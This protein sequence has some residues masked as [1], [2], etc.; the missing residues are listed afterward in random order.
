MGFQ[1]R[2]L[3]YDVDTPAWD[4]TL[5]PA[6]APD[7][8]KLVEPSVSEHH[9]MWPVPPREKCGLLSIRNGRAVVTLELEARSHALVALYSRAQRPFT[10]PTRYFSK[11]PA[12]LCYSPTAPKS[13]LSDFLFSY[14]CKLGMDVLTSGLPNNFNSLMTVHQ[15]F[16]AT[17]T[18]TT[19]PRPAVEVVAEFE[20]ALRE[21]IG[22]RV[23][24]GRVEVWRDNR[25]L[26][27]NEL[28]DGQMKRNWVT[29]RS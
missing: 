10:R 23:G 13:D 17:A 9:M 6:V 24:P 3:H 26:A 1:E 15:V 14:F 25:R 7:G 21:S 4:D 12:H 18:V 27:G 19:S 29:P 2:T 11:L 8:M 16:R 5:P 22:Q 28:F 20:K